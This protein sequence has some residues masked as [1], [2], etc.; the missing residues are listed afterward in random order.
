MKTRN[1]ALAVGGGLAAAVAVK[2]I[3]RPRTVE[4]E[5]VSHHLP[6]ADHSHFVT[7][8]G[9]GIHYQE[10][11]ERSNPPM[12][13]LHGYTAS[14]YVWKTVAPMF[15][16]AGFHVIA[17]DM[18]GF[19]YSDKPSSFDYTIDSQARMISR[20]MDREGVGSAVVVGSS[21]GGA[22]AATLALDYPARV[23]KLVLVDAVINDDVRN[24][25]ILKLASIPAVGEVITPFL[26]DSKRF[27]RMRMHKTLAP[28]NH[29]LITDDRLANVQ[30]PLTNAEGH[31]A[32]LATSRNWHANRIEQDAHLIRQPTLIVWGEE[33]RITPTK[34]A[35][36]LY[37]SILQSRLVMIKDC[38]HVPQEEKSDVFTEVVTRFCHDPKDV[39]AFPNAAAH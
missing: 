37:D 25:P 16:E 1:L 19:G 15:A 5:R 23:E 30:R 36:K 7:V 35:H 2:M 21:Y 20:F 34:H 11:G 29:S 14:A 4:W 38:G 27:M 6:H 3:V 26:I 32:I 10:F 33:D 39:E 8:D 24:H 22:V 9:S 12:I 18:L 31:R 17:P 13:L 28:A